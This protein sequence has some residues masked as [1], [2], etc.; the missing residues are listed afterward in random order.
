[1]PFRP[2]DPPVDENND[3]PFAEFPSEPAKVPEIPKNQDWF[4]EFP[5]EKANPIA[6]SKTWGQLSRSVKNDNDGH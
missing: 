4:A 6:R 5:D 2:S 1:M 3:D